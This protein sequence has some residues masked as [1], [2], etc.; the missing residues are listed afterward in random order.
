MEVVDRK[1]K[2]IA[3]SIKS[4]KK[5]TEKNALLFLL[6]DALLP[7]M[8]DHYFYLLSE[9]HADERQL[10]GIRLLKDRVLRWQ[11]ANPKKVK[12]PDIER[13]EEERRV[14]KANRK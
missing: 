4:E 6:K 9:R 14:C 7:D 10:E 13:G 11:R 1:F 2:I 8:L 5:Y 12:L 3:V